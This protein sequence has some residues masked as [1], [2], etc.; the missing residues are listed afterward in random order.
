MS[1]DAM[2]QTQLW[3]SEHNMH[4]P[5]TLGSSQLFFVNGKK[6]YPLNDSSTIKHQTAESKSKTA[7]DDTNT[8]E[9]IN[10]ILG[11]WFI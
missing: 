5:G 1:F 10:G 11:F 7:L 6:D 8:T 9:N 4:N 2:K 3:A